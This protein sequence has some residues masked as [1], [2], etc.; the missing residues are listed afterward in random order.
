MTKSPLGASLCLDNKRKI[1]GIITD[2][3]IRKSINKGLN[4]N[5]SVESIINFNPVTINESTS[6]IE[7]MKIMEDRE[8]QIS[9]LP[10]VDKDDQCI[11]LLRLHDL[12][13][14]KLV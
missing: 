9:I 13:Q 6:L 2:G 12:F 1:L 14:T 3:D 8:S 11:G 5:D 4:P 10:V 7:A